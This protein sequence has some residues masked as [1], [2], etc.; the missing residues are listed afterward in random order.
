MSDPGHS[1]LSAADAVAA[2]KTLLASIIDRRPS[3]TRQRLA[4]TLAKN[5]SFVSQ[6]TNP[7][8]TTPI[9]AIHIEAILDVCHASAEERRHFLALYAIAHPRRP[10]RKSE[11]ATDAAR[12]IQ[13]PDL[14]DEA[15]NAKLHALVNGFIR[16][17]ASLMIEDQPQLRKRR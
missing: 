2:Y 3:G 13:L 7:A 17:L 11:P 8:Y 6:I 9:P 5:R 10:S 16:Q 4:T 1:N 14:G 15:R 12:A